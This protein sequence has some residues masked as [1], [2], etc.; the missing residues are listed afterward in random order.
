M[1]FIYDTVLEQIKK[2][3]GNHRPERGGALLG[4]P[5]K[6]IVSKFIFDSTALTTASTYSPSR[7]LN[8]LVKE[9]EENEGLEYKGIIHSHPG[10][11][12]QPSGQDISELSTG[13]RLNPHMPFYLVPIVTLNN[14]D[15]LEDHEL[16]VGKTKISFYAGYRSK[17]PEME[18]T[19]FESKYDDI[20]LRNVKVQPIPKGLLTRDVEALCHMRAGLRNPQVFLVNQEIQPMLACTL[21]MEDR[22][23]LLMVVDSHYPACKPSI[24]VTDTDGNQQEFQPDWSEAELFVQNLDKLITSLI[25]AGEES[26]NQGSEEIST[27]QLNPPLPKR[28]K[29][30]RPRI[31]N[32]F[33]RRMARVSKRKRSKR[34]SVRKSNESSE[35]RFLVETNGTKLITHI[36]R[37][38]FEES[39][40]VSLSKLLLSTNNQNEEEL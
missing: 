4:Q 37:H 8:Q 11:L 6:A 12:D 23:D 25:D 16:A 32:R 5:G 34:H 31:F 24:L 27:V 15:L 18:N 40:R 13:L 33:E 1:L 35:M 36:S 17:E 28:S 10:K 30:N 39:D 2:D 3:I 26:S 9:T 29:R 38:H 22:F 19:G 21:E 14:I 7:R 20:F